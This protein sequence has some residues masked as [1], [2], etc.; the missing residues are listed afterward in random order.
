MKKKR[1]KHGVPLK[2]KLKQT[3]L[4]T[5]EVKIITKEISEQWG[6]SPKTAKLDYAYLTNAKKKLFLM[7][8]ELD[9]LSQNEII[10]QLTIERVGL[11]FGDQTDGGLRLTM[12]GSQLIG[13]QAKQ[14]VV[15][16]DEAEVE[17]W[18]YGRPIVKELDMKK[19]KMTGKGYIILKHKNKLSGVIDYLGC[20]RYKEINGKHQIMNF[21][22]KIRRRVEK[23]N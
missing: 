23:N 14:N 12:E 21:V 4:S 13:P 22:P 6:L 1:P 10:G 17:E 19:N 7:N 3:I 2:R 15:A 11:Y 18:F 8:R 9:M 20:G 5:R 16:L